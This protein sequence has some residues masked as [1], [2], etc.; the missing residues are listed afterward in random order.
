MVH[1]FSRKIQLIPMQLSEI[2]G[3]CLKR[4]VRIVDLL[5]KIKGAHRHFQFVMVC[6]AW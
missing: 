5:G 2:H 6:M 4:V 3:A 1:F